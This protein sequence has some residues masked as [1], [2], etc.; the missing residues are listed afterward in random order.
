MVS[1]GLKRK[2]RHFSSRTSS[3]G[4][5]GIHKPRAPVSVRYS[6]QNVLNKKYFIYRS[7]KVDRYNN[8]LL[9][10]EY[11]FCEQLNCLIYHSPYHTSAKLTIKIFK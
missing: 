11:W 9:M 3:I 4:R 10:L 6:W 5:D 8:A 1:S 7:K 2:C